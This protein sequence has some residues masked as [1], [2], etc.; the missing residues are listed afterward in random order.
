MGTQRPR[1]LDQV[2]DRIRRLSYSYRTEKT[3][4]HWIR[5]FILFHGKR[6]PTDMGAE[7]V[8]AYLTHLAVKRRVSASTQNQALSAILFLYRQVL[9]TELPWMENIVRAKRPKRLP[10]VLSRG[11]VGAVLGHLQEPFWLM[12]SLLYGSGLRVSECLRLRIKDLDFE[13]RQV[14]VRNGKGAK[15]RVTMLPD[16][17]TGPIHARMQRLTTLFGSDR[18]SEVAGASMPV[19]LARKYPAARREWS[20]QF[21][22]PARRP[23]RDHESGLQVRHHAH[24]KPLQRAVR[25]AVRNAGINKP[26]SC[27]TFR[28]CF[29]THLLENGYDIRTVQE[30][31]GHK[32]VSTTMIYTH[33]LKKGGRGVR[34]P[35]D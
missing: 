17:L 22:F 26:A 29:A 35:L 19:A 31:L 14:T 23:A 32:D 6:H 34:S 27:H 10:V 21:L 16:T 9:E 1:L 13:Y 24:E 5:R 33:V 11:E 8:E 7:E 3:Y 28:H 4:V 12:A 30:L 15:D 2:R 25:S 20:W 18:D